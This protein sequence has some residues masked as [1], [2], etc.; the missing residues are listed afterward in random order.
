MYIH[1]YTVYIFNI[2]TARCTSNLYNTCMQI[3]LS[4][5][6]CTSS[7]ER[8]LYYHLSPAAVEDAEF[9]TLRLGRVLGEDVQDLADVVSLRV[10]QLTSGA[11]EN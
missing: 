9:E 4:V 5:Y 7:Y 11:L 6:L 2:R 8:G 10:P 1:R 3:C